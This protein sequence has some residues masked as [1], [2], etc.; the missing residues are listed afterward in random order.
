MRKGEAESAC[1][2]GRGRVRINI[3]LVFVSHELCD[4][5]SYDIF[6]DSMDVGV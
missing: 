5:W 4:T 2:T 3:L 1:L 6:S